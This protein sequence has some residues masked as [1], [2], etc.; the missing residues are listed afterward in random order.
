VKKIQVYGHRGYRSLHPE[1]SAAGYEAM[2]AA[3]VDFADM[4]VALTKDGEVVVTHDLALNPDVVRGPDGKFLAESQEAV[5]AMPELERL[6]YIGKY[7][8]NAL[9]MAEL[10]RYDIGRLNPA[11]R[12]STL[13]PRQTFSDGSPFLT[14]REVVR[15]LKKATA[16]EIGF[17]VEMKTAPQFPLLSPDPDDFAQKVA[18]VLE[19]ERVVGKTEVQ[20]FDFRCLEAIRKRS[21]WIKTAYL[22]TRETDPAP[23]PALVKAQGGYAWEPEDHQLTQSSLEEARALG[24]KVVVWSWPEKNGVDFDPEMTGKMIDWGVDGIITDDPARLNQLLAARGLPVPKRY[25]SGNIF[26]TGPA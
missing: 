4:D 21:A 15:A 8:V 18:Q 6:R 12:Y 1:H 2:L 5:W 9:T 3:G 10:R 20:S 22:T 23:M 17:Q 13:F 26:G 24:L 7:A 25:V 14:L 16:G 19:E 11:S